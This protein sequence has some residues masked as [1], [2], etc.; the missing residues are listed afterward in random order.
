MPQLS[1][2]MDSKVER[3]DKTVYFLSFRKKA[4]QQCTLYM[5][6]VTMKFTL[7]TH[8]FW[9]NLMLTATSTTDQNEQS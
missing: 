8:T 4:L 3:R 7:Y 1:L 5:Y 9:V 6:T 2:K